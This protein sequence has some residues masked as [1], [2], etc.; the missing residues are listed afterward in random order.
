MKVEDPKEP[1][2]EESKEEEKEE[3]TP[4]GTKSNEVVPFQDM[5]RVRKIYDQLWNEIGVINSK[6]RVYP[7]S[8]QSISTGTWTTVTL[9]QEDYD[10]N[11]EFASNK[12]TAKNSGYYIVSAAIKWLSTE[13]DKQYVTYIYKN[14]NQQSYRATQS[15]HST[16]MTSNI[17]DIIYLDK[18][19]Y[20]EMKALHNGASSINIAGDSTATFLAIHRL[21]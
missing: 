11:D 21:S 12:F 8:N 19:D 1:P 5:L 2:K 13:T 15:S 20:I 3:E 7:N 10:V 9:D 4:F 14:G 16:S 17:T 6:V 18:G